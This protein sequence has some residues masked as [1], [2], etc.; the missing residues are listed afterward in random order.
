MQKRQIPNL[1]TNGPCLT[2]ALYF[3]EKSLPD[4]LQLLQ[5]FSKGMKALYL[6]N[7]KRHKR[8]PRP[9]DRTPVYE[10]GNG[11]S[12]LPGSTKSIR[13]AAQVVDERRTV[14]PIHE[15]RSGFESLP[16]DKQIGVLADMVYARD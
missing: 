15:K 4:F 7:V 1:E 6:C 10:T 12:T 8:S 13:A 9:M 11:S 2:V 14:N 5:R 16:P 3:F